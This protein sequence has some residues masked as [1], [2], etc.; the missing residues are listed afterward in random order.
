MTDRI[1]RLLSGRSTDTR[2]STSVETLRPHSTTPTRAIPRENVGVGVARNAAFTDHD[3]VGSE[4]LR[5]FD[6]VALIDS[7]VRQSADVVDDQVVLVAD[8]ELA[9]VVVGIPVVRRAEQLERDA[10][11]AD[12]VTHPVDLA[13]AT[14]EPR[15]VT[16]TDCHVDGSSV[17]RLGPRRYHYNIALNYRNTRAVISWNSTDRHRHGH[18]H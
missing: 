11:Y 9:A 8:V 18:R 1:Y 7:G 14:V 6:R 15:L 2:N 16:S 12:H 10:G 17:P 4:E 13:A 5:A 3:Q